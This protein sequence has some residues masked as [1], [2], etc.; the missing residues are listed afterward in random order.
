MRH[1]GGVNRADASYPSRRCAGSNVPLTAR[2]THFDLHEETVS[3]ESQ[4]PGRLEV[5]CLSP[6]PHA[7][8]PATSA[9]SHTSVSRIRSVA[10]LFSSPVVSKNGWA[11]EISCPSGH[12]EG[13]GGEPVKGR[14]SSSTANEETR[15]SS[16]VRTLLPRMTLPGSSFMGRVTGL[17]VDDLVGIKD[18]TDAHAGHGGGAALVG[19]ESRTRTRGVALLL[20]GPAQALGTTLVRALDPPAAVEGSGRPK[21]HRKVYPPGGHLPA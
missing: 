13:G 14:G 18:D 20:T 12:G 6:E 7:P 8:V 11:R 2:S 1:P 3:G 4:T 21:G 15:I 19:S 17:Q 16:V 9:S 10:L 5:P